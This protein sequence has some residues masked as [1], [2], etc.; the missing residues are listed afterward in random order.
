M[1]SNFKILVLL[2]LSSL[3]LFISCK[4]E[5]EI[6]LP[7]ITIISPELGSTIFKEGQEIQ[8]KLFVESEIGLHQLLLD[9]NV[10][11]VWDDNEKEDEVVFSYLVEEEISS[12]NFNLTDNE[13]NKVDLIYEVD[14]VSLPLIKITT[15]IN[16]F[17]QLFPEVGEEFTIILRVTADSGLKSLEL[18]NEQLKQWDEL[19]YE[20]TIIYNS[21]AND[22][23]QYN[24]NFRLIDKDNNEAK[25]VSIS[26]IPKITVQVTF[27]VDMTG[28]DVSR[29]VFIGG[30]GIGSLKVMEDIGDNIYAYQVPMKAGTTGDYYFLN[31]SEFA[32]IYYK[33]REEIPVRCATSITQ[34]APYRSFTIDKEDQSNGVVFSAVWGKCNDSKDNER[35]FFLGD[36]ITAL[37]NWE[38]G[39]IQLL[40]KLLVNRGLNKDLI[41]VGISGNT[42][43]DLS[44]RVQWDVIEAS[45]SKVFVYIGI[46]DLWEVESDQFK[47]NYNTLIQTLKTIDTEIILVTPALVGEKNN[48]GNPNDQKLNEFAQTV[49]DLAIEHSLEW[50]NLRQLC[51]DYLKE[52]NPNN[53]S[54][55]IL[56]TDGI[57][58]NDQGNAFLAQIFE[59]FLINEEI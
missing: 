15:P 28:I 29:G 7:K 24:L 36:S 57:H 27:Q 30:R 49:E 31:G 34:V 10:I 54:S 39:Y 23:S 9:N 41:G 38:G 8:F 52:N 18:N 1:R 32:G 47:L 50:I 16:P 43:T 48:N 20:D 58:M 19:M 35:I 51:I 14:Y 42:V 12:L 53:L 44:D 33:Y 56:T 26:V 59:A 17:F 40:E 13:G 4:K 5:E 21:T 2:V 55:G 45:P 11:K 46:N 22:D 3:W 25:A 6:G 37:G